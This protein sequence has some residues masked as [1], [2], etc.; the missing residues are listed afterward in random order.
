LLSVGGL[1][2][3]RGVHPYETLLRQAVH[4]RSIS[5]VSPSTTL[6]TVITWP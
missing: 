4:H 2:G 6:K 5:M 3:L 1:R